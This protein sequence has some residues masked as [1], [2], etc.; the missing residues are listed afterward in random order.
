[1]DK[2]GLLAGLFGNNPYF[3]AGFGL[4]GLGIG[5]Q[6]LRKGAVL[7]S[8]SLRRRMLVTLEL[9]N[10]DPVYPWFLEWMAHQTRASAASPTFLSRLTRSHQLAVETVVQEREN[11]SK[12]FQFLL[13]AGPG[14][15]IFK[16]HGAWVQVKRERDTRFSS[17][18]S[19]AARVPWETVTLT[20]LSRDR[21]LFP[22]LLAEARDVAL[23]K[24]QGKLIVYTA[25]DLSWRPFGKPLQK[26]PLNSVILAPGDSTGI[27]YRRGYL[28]KGPPGSGKSSFIQALAGS[29][30][31]DIC[32]L[33][34]SERGMG[35]DRLQHRLSNVPSGCIILIEDVDAAF[36]KR[37]QTSEDGYQSSVTFSG[38]LNALDG[39]VSGEER[40][41]FMTTNHPEKLDP[42]LIRPGRVDLAE[43]IDDAVPEQAKSL[44]IHFYR[45]S[46]EE[47]KLLR[48]GETLERIVGRAMERGR[49]ISMASLQGL[50]IQTN[51]EDVVKICGELLGE[52][53]MS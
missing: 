32:L 34:L 43:L 51:V 42:A 53:S 46:E 22:A 13:V 18:S 1:M 15:H 21:T 10:K 3:E 23:Q 30:G 29:L 4:M 25:W 33:N 9:N 35:D 31:Y 19:E 38:F 8:S 6:L 36:N 12:S 48:L 45:G 17:S 27:P 26:R 49:R 11:G 14:T 24:I 16:Y 47:E 50:F 5:A 37:A 52:E 41:V 40:I 39:V 2:P 44:F 7:G 28:L 20:T